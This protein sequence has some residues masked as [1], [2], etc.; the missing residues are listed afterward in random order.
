[1]T[2]KQE[3]IEELKE[4][5]LEIAEESIEKIVKSVIAIS[6]KAL[7]SQFVSIVD[8]TLDKIEEIIL[9]QVDKIDGQEG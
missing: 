6:K 5:G 7:P 9:Q 1:M 8:P 3:L 2:L 4:Q